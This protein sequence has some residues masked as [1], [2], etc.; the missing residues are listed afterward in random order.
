VRRPAIR[1]KILG[2]VPSAPVLAASLGRHSFPTLTA[3]L[4]PTVRDDACGLAAEDMLEIRDP[5]R[6]RAREDAVQ[7]GHNLPPR[8]QRPSIHPVPAD[9]AG[10]SRADAG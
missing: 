5:C 3:L 8:D 6:F 10:P 9:N 2:D 1:L 4:D 7:T